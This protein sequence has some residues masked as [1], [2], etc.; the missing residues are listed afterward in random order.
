MLE[1]VEIEGRGRGLVAVADISANQTIEIAP[2]ALVPIGED[3]YSLP[4]VFPWDW[5]HNAIAFGH[6]SMC[7]HS[8]N[9]NCR[10]EIDDRSKKVKLIAN[11]DIVPGDEITITYNCKLWFEAGA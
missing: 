3:P 7:N 8:Y 2:L 9:P 1:V 4:W 10:W 11:W 6:I 5:E